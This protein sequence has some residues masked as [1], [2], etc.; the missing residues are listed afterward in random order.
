MNSVFGGVVVNVP[1]IGLK[2]RGFKPGRGYTFLKAI[3]LRNTPSFG[4]EV[5]PSAPYRKILQHVKDPCGV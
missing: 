1:A 2:S 3:K 5:K 4:G